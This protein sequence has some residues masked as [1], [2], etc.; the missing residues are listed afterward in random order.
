MNSDRYNLLKNDTNK[1]ES[2]IICI[3][4]KCNGVKDIINQI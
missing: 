3:N 1:Y 4:D 2:E